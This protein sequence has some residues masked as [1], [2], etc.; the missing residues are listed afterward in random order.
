[1]LYHA[2]I[3][4][5][6]Y[7]QLIPVQATPKSA[8]SFYKSMSKSKEREKESDDTSIDV[9]PALNRSM[10]S[11]GA[12]SHSDVSSPPFPTLYFPSPINHSS[13]NKPLAIDTATPSP[14]A[15]RSFDDAIHDDDSGLRKSLPPFSGSIYLYIHT[16]IHTYICTTAY[17]LLPLRIIIWRRR[18]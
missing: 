9:S 8:R 1:M 2:L 5:P 16:Y 14:L 10:M 11:N 6:S 18:L 17:S 4:S 3:S 12:D 13:A 7:L 15:L